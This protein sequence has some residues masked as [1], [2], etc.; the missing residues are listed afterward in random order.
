M[1]L[2][3]VGMIDKEDTSLCIRGNGKTCAMVFY[4]YLYK[5]KGYI[6]WTNFKTTFSDDIIGFQEMINR[7]KK[8]YKENEELKK[9]GKKPIEHKIV[10][11]VTEMQELISS[12]G[13]DNNQKLFV[14]HFAGQIR[15]LNADCLY[16]TQFLKGVQINLRRHTEN[17]RIPVKYHLDGEQCNFDRCKKP[18]II[19]IFSYKPFK[20]NPIRMIK[21]HVVGKLY[22]SDE[23]IEDKLILPKEEKIK[24]EKIKKEEDKNA[25]IE[26]QD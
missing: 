25:R 2:A 15:K 18:H 16:D 17:I 1:F 11:G 26:C 21:S 20:E 8:L 5:K 19:K 10:L 14:T 12:V 23:I 22:D 13:S 3:F 9:Q 4:L 6:V 7:L 24:R